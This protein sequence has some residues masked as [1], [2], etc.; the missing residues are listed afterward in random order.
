MPGGVAS[1]PLQTDR[2]TSKVHQP[3]REPTSSRFQR[4]IADPRASIP[5]LSVDDMPL[6]KLMRAMSIAVANGIQEGVKQA[7]DAVGDQTKRKA[8]SASKLRSPVHRLAKMEVD[9]EDRDGEY[10]GD[11]EEEEEAQRVRSSTRRG[12]RGRRTNLFHVSY[13]HLV[14]Y[15]LTDF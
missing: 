5:D 3:S 7:V 14:D 13:V 2:K 11:E 1:H 15:W 8:A 4:P 10:D 12:P 6:S 9:V